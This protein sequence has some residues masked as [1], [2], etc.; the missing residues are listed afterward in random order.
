MLKKLADDL[1]LL[2]KGTILPSEFRFRNPFQ[3]ASPLGQA[4]LANVEHYIAD[5]D[6]RAIDQRYARMQEREMA[7]LIRLLRESAE[8]ELL[9]KIRFLVES[10]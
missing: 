5:F 4:I 10:V 9:R 6:I 3:S 2:Q 8:E 1:E 7:R